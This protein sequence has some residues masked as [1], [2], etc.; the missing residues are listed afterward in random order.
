MRKWMKAFVS[1]VLVMLLVAAPL[2]AM[3]ATV[4]IYR[5]NGDLVR[6]HS[7]AKQGLTNVVGKLRKGSKVFYLG[8]T[9]GWWRVRSDRGLTGYVYNTYLSYYKSADLSRVYR[10]T[11]STYVY[12]KAS[13]GAKKIVTLA[14]YEHVIVLATKGSWAAIETL[15]GKKGFV[16]LNKLRKAS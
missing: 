14:K 4:K 7:T 16:K 9:G 13:T 3:A 1:L 15:Y 5:V 11:G 6:V 10:T 2:E 12:K 8:K